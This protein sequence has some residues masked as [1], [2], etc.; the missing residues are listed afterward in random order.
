M[1]AFRPE[2]ETEYSKG[3][4][5]SRGADGRSAKPPL[6]PSPRV[7]LG[8]LAGGL[9]GALL[10]IVAEFTP[11]AQVRTAGHHVPLSTLST[12]S[13]NAYAMIPLALLAAVFSLVV[14]R[15]DRA[16]QGGRHPVHRL[17]MLGVALLGLASLLIALLND[18][19]D[20]HG[21]GLVGS[22]TTHYALASVTASIGLYLE[23]LGAVF[24]LLSG[25]ASLLLVPGP[26]PVQPGRP[27]PG[28]PASERPS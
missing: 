6:G 10:L 14:W 28:I 3:G 21:T 9:L 8:V 7:S 27:Q 17:M 1:T 25:V 26:P 5:P 18:L 2:A 16:G 15:A 13:H 20:A 12:G 4:A 24:L 11:M 22:A 19:P 23:T